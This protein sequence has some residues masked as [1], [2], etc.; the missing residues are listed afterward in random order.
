[1]SAYDPPPPEPNPLGDTEGDDEDPG[2]WRR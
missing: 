2:E 1:M